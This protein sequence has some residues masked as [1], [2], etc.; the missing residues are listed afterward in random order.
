MSEP[1]L[2]GLSPRE[3]PLLVAAAIIAGRG[4]SDNGSTNCLGER[5]QWWLPETGSC[6]RG[7]RSHVP[8]GQATPAP[9]D[10]TA[11]VA[12]GLVSEG[13]SLDAF[14]AELIAAALSKAAGNQTRAASLLGT[15]RR[16]LQYRME[17]HGIASNE[18][19]PRPARE[20][21][22]RGRHEAG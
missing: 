20:D 14:E 21:G 13:F 12:R 11:T 9:Q 5:C 3:C 18:R 22:S 6:G 1:E 2:G 7:D 15:T 19:E 8:R 16:T 17:K 4:R 10:D